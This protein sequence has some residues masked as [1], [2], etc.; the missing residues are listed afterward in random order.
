MIRIIT[1]YVVD[2]KEFDSEVDAEDYVRYK[3][4]KKEYDKNPNTFVQFYQ[5]LDTIRMLPEE[6]AELIKIVKNLKL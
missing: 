4:I 5:L 3:E 2:D 6:I 1:K